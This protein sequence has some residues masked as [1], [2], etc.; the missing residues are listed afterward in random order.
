[1]SHLRSSQAKIQEVL[2][3]EEEDEEIQMHGLWVYP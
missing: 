3:K 2:R 1:M